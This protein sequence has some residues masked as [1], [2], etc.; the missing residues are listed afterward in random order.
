MGGA[1]SICPGLVIDLRRMR[2]I[3]H[4]DAESRSARVQA[5]AVLEDVDLALNPAGFILGHDP[6][7]V[8][9]ATIGGAI[10]TNSVG[11]R[12]GIYGSMGEQV[13][14]L[15]AVMP[16]GE[17][18]QIRRQNTRRGLI[19]MLCSSAARAVSASLPKRQFVFSQNPRPVFRGFLFATFEQGYGAIQEM[20]CGGCDQRCSTSAMM[21]R[22][23][24]ARFSI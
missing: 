23:T 9:V 20:F 11:Y 8:P 7:T 21:P 13:L 17:V 24:T 2:S 5:G 4:I 10:S 3:L 18:L 16:N 19:S 12:A 14:G 22:S 15:E 1:L 6:G